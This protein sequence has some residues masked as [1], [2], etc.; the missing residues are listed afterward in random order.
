MKLKKRN[1]DF[2]KLGFHFFNEYAPLPPPLLTSKKYR[3]VFKISVRHLTLHES[4]IF[5]FL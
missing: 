4:T 2:L 1:I 5:N 3:K